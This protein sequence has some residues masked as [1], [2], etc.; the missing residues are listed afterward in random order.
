MISLCCYGNLNKSI[1]N[2]SSCL[3]CSLSTH[4]LFD[5]TSHPPP[6]SPPLSWSGSLPPLRKTEIMIL[7]SVKD[8]HDLENLPGNQ[9]H[10]VGPDRSQCVAVAGI[11]WSADTSLSG[12][13]TQHLQEAW[14]C[15]HTWK[16]NKNP[17]ENISVIWWQYNHSI[18]YLLHNMS[19]FLRSV[20]V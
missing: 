15:D 7:P 6:H 1:A 11:Y 12:C 14:T 2:A 18:R 13:L 9:S 4:G 20:T 3:L 16:E 10:S 19:I 8:E 17:L 5:H